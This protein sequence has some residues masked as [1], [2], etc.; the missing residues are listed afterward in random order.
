MFNI[1]KIIK[2]TSD[3]TAGRFLNIEIKIISFRV[4]PQVLCL[5]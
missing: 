3:K 5:S 1:A 2:K 4:M